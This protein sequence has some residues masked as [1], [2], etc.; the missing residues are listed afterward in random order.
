MARIVYL[1]GSQNG[2]FG[3]KTV[4]PERHDY[5]VAGHP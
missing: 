5:E 1:H 4:L 3:G 2:L